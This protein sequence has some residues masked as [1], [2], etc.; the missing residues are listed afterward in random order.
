MMVTPSFPP[1]S[2]GNMTPQG[3]PWAPAIPAHWL[4]SAI[5]FLRN[6]LR[7]LPDKVVIH[8]EDRRCVTRHW[9]ACEQ[10]VNVWQ[11]W[12]NMLCFIE[13]SAKTQ[14]TA[15]GAGCKA[16]LA[17]ACPVAWQKT[18]FK[19]LGCI[20]VSGPRTKSDSE[21]QRIHNAL[22]RA[23]RVSSID[24]AWPRLLRAYRGFVLSLV[25]FGLAGRSPTESLAKKL[26]TWVGKASSIGCSAAPILRRIVFGATAD[27]LCTHMCRG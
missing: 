7:S 13:S 20:S 17:E 5:C 1:F 24:L 3:C 27:L 8:V 6:S 26:F 16:V 10:F 18:E 11:Q 25:A 19:V 23:A 9:A 4:N 2:V 14:L 15:K 21:Q 22:A 12:S